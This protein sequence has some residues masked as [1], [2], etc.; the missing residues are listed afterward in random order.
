MDGKLFSESNKYLEELLVIDESTVVKAITKLL[1][2]EVIC[3]VDRN[4][5][6]VNIER[7]SS[8]EFQNL[9]NEYR[10]KEWTSNEFLYEIYHDDVCINSKRELI[11]NSFD[12]LIM[13]TKTFSETVYPKIEE[14][15]K[16]REIHRERTK[17]EREYK[18]KMNNIISYLKNV[19]IN[20][21]LLYKFH[22][23]PE[24]MSNHPD[25]TK[26]D[27]DLK[28]WEITLTELIEYITENRK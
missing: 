9:C 26:L 19:D 27:R 17:F 16:A 1:D 8:K 25:K 11:F 24:L 23:T 22:T 20:T 3:Y 21:E 2:L 10:N 4:S 15:I 28:G 5:M 7:K 6:N 13:R 14:V 12:P 18:F